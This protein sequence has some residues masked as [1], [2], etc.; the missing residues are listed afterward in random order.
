MKTTH[1]IFAFGV[2]ALL[3]V[4][5]G[6]LTGNFELKMNDEVYTYLLIS[7]LTFDVL[8]GFILIFGK[9]RSTRKKK[10]SF[11]YLKTHYLW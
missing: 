10:R 9:I 1:K 7:F 8:L 4:G 6:L 3:V 5:T 2:L 11:S